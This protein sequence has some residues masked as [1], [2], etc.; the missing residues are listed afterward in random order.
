MAAVLALV[1]REDLNVVSDRSTISLLSYTD[2]FNLEYYNGWAMAMAAGMEPGNVYESLDLIAKGATHDALATYLRGLDTKIMQTEQYWDAEIQK[3]SVWLRMQL[4]GETYARQALIRRMSGRI[5]ESVY[6]P[7]TDAGCVMRQYTLGIE[8][9]PWWENT[10]RISM[11]VD[12]D[13]LS[14]DG[15]MES[16][17]NDCVGNV[18]ARIASTTI[19]VNSGDELNEL[20]LGF[21]TSRM[22]T[23]TDFEPKWLCGSGTVIADTGTTDEG[24]WMSCDFSAGVPD[25]NAMQTR[26]YIKT[27]DVVAGAKTGDQR[28][29]FVVLLRA[30]LSSN[31]TTCYVRLLDGYSSTDS[32]LRQQDRVKIT[33]TSWL[34]YPLGTISIPPSRGIDI[35]GSTYDPDSGLMDDFRMAIQAQRVAGGTATLNFDYLLLVPITEGGI[36]V[37]DLG[38]E[39]E[40]TLYIY[41]RPEDTVAAWTFTSGYGTTFEAVAPAPAGSCGYS[42]P[43]GAP[44]VVCAG[45]R[46]TLHDATDT[47][48]LHS[49]VYERWRSLRGADI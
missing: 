32:N 1:E 14:V 22:G 9:L 8:R 23:V 10:T 17:S 35:L 16:L 29:E 12:N 31:A 30:Q 43:V 13:A 5:G 27:S 49:Y 45:Q 19:Q 39:S 34:L 7:Y 15:G 6:G 4:S 47:I 2:G 18:P 33:S 20:W 46:A 24:T 21:R 40:Q 37:G 48:K 38:L 25:G 42:M 26:F 36:Y 41:T 3:Y 44:Y 11:W 28:G